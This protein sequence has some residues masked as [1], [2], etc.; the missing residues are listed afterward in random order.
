MSVSRQVPAARSDPFGHALP[1]L[2]TG[3]ASYLTDL[4]HQQLGLQSRFLR[5]VLI[6]RG[7]TD[8]V[9]ETDRREALLVGRE[10][11]A[12]LAEG[13]SGFM[14]TIKRRSDNPY[15]SETG[16]APLVD[17][18]NAEKLLPRHYINEAGNNITSDFKN[19]ALP[20]IDGPLPPLA[21]LTRRSSVAPHSILYLSEGTW[22]FYVLTS[23]LLQTQS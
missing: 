12:H 18:A 8:S 19:Y 14:V 5:P 1:T 6:G 7:F 17:V 10:A 23:I 16:L 20:L 21:R 15:H 22:L 9:A 11:A 13:R 2:T 3:V 4:V